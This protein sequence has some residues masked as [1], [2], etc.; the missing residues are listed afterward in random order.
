MVIYFATW[1]EDNQGITLT[2]AEANNRLL[3]YFFLRAVEDQDE[4]YK[5]YIG[6][7]TI[8]SVKKRFDK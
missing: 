7:G 5:T 2:K 4:F 1:L 3:S 6:K 8:P